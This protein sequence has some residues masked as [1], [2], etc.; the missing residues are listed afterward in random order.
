MIL[1]ALETGALYEGN[2]QRG[3][4]VSILDGSPMPLG[5]KATNETT[6]ISKTLWGRWKPL[7]SHRIKPCG[8]EAKQHKQINI[9]DNQQ[10][11]GDKRKHSTWDL[12]ICIN[13]V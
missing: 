12:D 2:A 13:P 3:F 1:R 6:G 10:P 9:S 8:S 7:D 4:G 5:L 11:S